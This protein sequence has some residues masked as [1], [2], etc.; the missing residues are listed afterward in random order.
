MAAL[1]TGMLLLIATALLPKVLREMPDFEV[2]YRAGT[3]TMA[4][5]ALYRVED[6]HYQDKYLPVFGIL[7][8]P[9]ALLPPTSAKIVWFYASIGAIA[10]LVAMSL[11]FL[12]KQKRSRALLASV[13]S[14][15]ML[16]FFARE[17]NLGQCNVLMGVLVVAGFM[18]L[19][20]ERGAP[21]GLVF[22]L[23]VAV[24]PYAVVVLPYLLLKRRATAAL[25]FIACLLAAL[26]LPAAIYGWGGNLMQLA[27]WLRTVTASTPDN[28]LNQDNVSIWAMWA[29]W[30]GAGLLASALAMATIAALGVV[31]LALLVRGRAVPRS[32]YLEMA[33]LLMLL[34]LLSPQGWDYG[35]LL[36]TPAVMLLINE[37]PGLPTAVRAASGAAVAVMAL[38][39]FDLMGRRAYAA[40]MSASPITVCA[41]VLFATIAYVRFRRI[42]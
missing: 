27:A 16:K 34:P 5:E 20:R 9:L 37:F 18:L 1:V 12:P 15:A 31:F 23:S 25:A 22:A 17:L 38:S 29:K 36:A 14:L 13:T 7:A 10:A 21:A 4:G 35:L 3:R 28:L 41:L 24:K 19:A 40:F 39:L 32:E 11:A 2:Y 8:A 30:L 26:I 42:A 6:G 33:A